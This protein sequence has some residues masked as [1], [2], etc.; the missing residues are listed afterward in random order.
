MK[1]VLLTMV[2]LASAT[3]PSQAPGQC[4]VGVKSDLFE[5]PEGSGIYCDH[6]GEF[7]AILYDAPNPIY[8]DIAE[9]INE[10][11]MTNI[12]LDMSD[13]ADVWSNAIGSVWELEYVDADVPQSYQDHAIRDYTA[14]LR[15]PGSSKKYFQRFQLNMCGILGEGF[16]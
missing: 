16:V 2:A 5:M 3:Y 9:E 7:N 11:I 13:A 4:N 10:T 14:S 8:R 12:Y 1:V 6:A 15:C